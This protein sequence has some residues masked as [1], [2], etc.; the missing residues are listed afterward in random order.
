VSHQHWPD[1]FERV[2]DGKHIVAEA[3]GSV[4]FGRKTGFAEAAPSDAVNVEGGR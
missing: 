4:A 2:E 3:I 1:Q